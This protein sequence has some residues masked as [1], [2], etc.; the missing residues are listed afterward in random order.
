M[1]R[2]HSLR[3][4]KLGLGVLC[5]LAPAA[6]ND[7]DDSG[8]DLPWQRPRTQVIA[9]GRAALEAAAPEGNDCVHYDGACIKPQEKCGEGVSSDVILD[10]HGR[11][12][13]I[14]C[15]PPGNELSVEEV[16]ARHGDI[17]QN[18]NKS[19]IHL[20]DVDD[21]AD[22]DGDLS[23][24]ANKVIVY[25]H[26]PDV[27]VISGKLVVDGNNIIVH[28][29]RI[30][31]DVEIPANNAFLVDCVIEGSLTVT[32]NNAVLTSTDVLGPT[33]VEGNN[34]ALTVNHLVGALY[35][36]GK[37]ARCEDNFSANDANDDG[38]IDSVEVGEA[39]SCGD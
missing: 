21:G 1:E 20:D 33:S 4:V 30:Q 8:G 24:D 11:V 28:G 10:D 38:I 6:C 32:G 5:A 31:G 26:G 2:N 29:V 3:L 16:E 23:I 7:D 35:V 17:A 25:G 15:Y 12:L 27:S 37:N 36:S 18:Q 9:G 13:E 39:L 22:L 19:V 14:V 34:A